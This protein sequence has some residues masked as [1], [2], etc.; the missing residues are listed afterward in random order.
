MRPGRITGEDMLTCRLTSLIYDLNQFY[1]GMDDGQFQDAGQATV[2]YKLILEHALR[3]TENPSIDD[4]VPPGNEEPPYQEYEND[5][6]PP[7]AYQENQDEDY[8]Q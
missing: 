2:Q 5:D 8:D 3:M 6:Q 1:R 7:P 4:D